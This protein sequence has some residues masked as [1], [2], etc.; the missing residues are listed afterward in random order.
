MGLKTRVRRDSVM[1]AL[2][3]KSNTNLKKNPTTIITIN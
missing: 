2:S 1:Q 3:Q